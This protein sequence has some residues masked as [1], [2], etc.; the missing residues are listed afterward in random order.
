MACDLRVEQLCADAATLT[1]LFPAKAE[2]RKD[3]RILGYP[4][5]MPG[6]AVLLVIRH[7]E[8]HLRLRD[9]VHHDVQSV[10]ALVQGFGSLEPKQGRVHRTRYSPEQIA[11]RLEV[12]RLAG[13]PPLDDPDLT[14]AQTKKAR[15]CC[16]AS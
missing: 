5:S 9:L 2:H 6:Y 16:R 13:R 1:G 10:P 11:N 15:H 3:G 12:S 8:R 4:Q 7:Q 14:A